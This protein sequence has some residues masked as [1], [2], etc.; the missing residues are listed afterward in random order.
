MLEAAL[1]LAIADLKQIIRRREIWLWTFVLPIVFFYFVGTITSGFAGGGSTKEPLAVQA[2]DDAG[3]LGEDLLVRL[4]KADFQV[5]R[6]ETS[7]DFA[8]AER[9]LTIPPHFTQS[10]LAREKMVLRS[11][12]RKADSGSSMTSCGCAGRRIRCWPTCSLAPP[13]TGSRA[14]RPFRSSTRCP[15]P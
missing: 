15:A 9:R 8:L 10:I 5:V 3:F 11:I 12:K 7:Q 6:P 2:P 14:R 1:H 13:W 4:K